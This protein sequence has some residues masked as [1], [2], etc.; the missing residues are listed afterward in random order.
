[1]E[2]REMLFELVESLRER[3]C[4]DETEHARVSGR[5]SRRR[6]SGC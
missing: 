2:H 4:R 6:T 5:T 1:L 3:A